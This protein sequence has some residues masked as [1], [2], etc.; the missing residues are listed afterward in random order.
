MSFITAGIYLLVMICYFQ[1]L[2]V[3]IAVIETAAD[4]FADTKRIIFVPL[5]YFLVGIVFFV[6]WVAGIIC[7]ASVGPISVESVE[8]Q[9]KDIEWDSFTTYSMWY[10]GFGIVWLVT[11][12][13]ACN[14]FVIIVSAITWYYSD[15]TIPD[16]DGIPGDSDV[17]E[18]FKWTFRYHMGSLAFG[19]LILSIVWIIRAAFEY[20]GEKVMDAAPGNGCTKCLVACIHCCLDCFDRF[21]RFLTRNAYIY[22]ALSGESFCSSALN[23]FVLILKNHA[24]FAFVDGIADVFMF[25][26]KF[27]I[28]SATTALSWLLMGVMTEVGDVFF[29]LFVIF[30][31]S[32]MIG[33]T[34]IAVFD[35]SANTILQCYL[36]DKE[37]ARSN[38]LQDPDHVPP[39]MEK[40]FKHPAV[41]SQMDK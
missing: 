33:S 41:A 40:F 19:S 18:G 2:R 24:K 9:S 5:I 31:L 29:P 22:M 28:A 37:I 14:E 15:K 6:M 10:M 23:A 36:L 3:A 27:F 21:L 13:I 12:I 38:G 11:F 8:S 7:V 32:Y 26:A 30:L 20:I 4:F 17:S 16:D 35:I 39:T 34:F 25:L 1:S